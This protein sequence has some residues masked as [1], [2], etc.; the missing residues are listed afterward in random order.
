VQVARLVSS[1][2]NRLFMARRAAAATRASPSGSVGRLSRSVF[3]DTNSTRMPSSYL[4]REAMSSGQYLVIHDLQWEAPGREPLTL[5][6]TAFGPIGVRMAKTIG[7]LVIAAGK[8]LRPRYGLGIRPGV[9]DRAQVDARWKPFSGSPLPPMER[10]KLG[11]AGFAESTELS[12]LHRPG[13]NRGCFPSIP[14]EA[15]SLCLGLR[16]SP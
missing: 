4:G 8:P 13:Y 5:G 6:R 7:P 11:R 3:G 12:L 14:D 1:G 16:S 9:P 2:W 15:V 10:S